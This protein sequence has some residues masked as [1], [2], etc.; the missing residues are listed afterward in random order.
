MTRRPC[1]T[2]GEVSEG[3]RCPE[4]T[5][6]RESRRPRDKT[7]VH[8]NTARWKRLSARLRKMSPFCELCGAT[9][10]L[11]VDHIARVQDRPEWTYEVA[12]LR[13]LCLR[14]NGRLSAQSATP[15][16][17]AEV[18]ARIRARKRRR[19]ALTTRG[20]TPSDLHVPSEVVAKFASHLPYVIENVA[21]TGR[22]WRVDLLSDS[23]PVAGR[24]GDGDPLLSVEHPQHSTSLNLVGG[25]P[26]VTAGMVVALRTQY[27]KV[28][29]RSLS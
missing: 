22:G 6:D 11:S 2:C 15:D 1:L 23:E 20:D 13:I 26:L 29:P 27:L 9:E 17:V 16:Q 3:S 8:F 4:H 28:H 21:G 19:V 12:N 24:V 25:V 5:R 14:C 7:H 18:E 10:R